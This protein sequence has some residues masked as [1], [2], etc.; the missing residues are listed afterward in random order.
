MRKEFVLP[1]YL[2]LSQ[3]ERMRIIG[4]KSDTS[5]VEFLD[6]YNTEQPS[7]SLSRLLE[8]FPCEEKVIKGQT[9]KVC[10]MMFDKHDELFD[11]I[12]D[13][14]EWFVSEGELDDLLEKLP[15]KHGGENYF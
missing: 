12:I 7:W 13:A 2:D 14:L 15:F 11:N 9:F 4:F 3:C 10:D 6:N 1:M 5:D 8:M